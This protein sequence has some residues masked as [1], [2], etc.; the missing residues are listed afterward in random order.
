LGLLIALMTA[1][2]VSCRADTPPDT[3]QNAPTPFSDN[4]GE[5]TEIFAMESPK[6]DISI[7]MIGKIRPF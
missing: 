7:Y 5:E 2:P 3:A 1:V 6:I 4:R